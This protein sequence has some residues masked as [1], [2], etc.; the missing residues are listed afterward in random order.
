MTI[1]PFMCIKTFDFQGRAQRVQRDFF[2]SQKLPKLNSAIDA[3]YVANLA[4]VNMWL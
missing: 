3:E 2:L 4:N 1:C